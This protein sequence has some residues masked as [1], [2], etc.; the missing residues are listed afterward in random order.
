MLLKH[1]NLKLSYEKENLYVDNRIYDTDPDQII[2][3]L[4]EYHN[5]KCAKNVDILCIV[6]EIT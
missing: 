1:Q 4:T 6:K 3:N 5:L 2:H